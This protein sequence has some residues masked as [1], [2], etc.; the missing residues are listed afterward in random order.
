M[1]Q[2]GRFLLMVILAAYFS[3]PV[4][5]QDVCAI[6]GKPITGQFYLVTDQVSGEQ[7]KVCS[8]CIL[9]PKCFICGLPVKTGGT[10]LSDGRW[11]C[12]RDS[13]TAVMDVDTARQTANETRDDL[14][15]VFS[16][17]TSWPTNVHI[18]VIDRI[19]V[20]TM[21]Q[22]AGNN[23]ESPNLM[24]CIQQV[25][26]G[27]KKHYEMRLLTGLP[28]VELRATAAHEFSHAWVGENVSPERHANIA[29][30]AE[31]GFCEMVAY[32]LMDSEGQ[33]AEKQFILRNHYTRGQVQLFIAAEQQYGFDQILDWMKYG[34]T[35]ELEGGHLDAI[36]DVKM[37]SGVA[38]T[39]SS[40]LYATAAKTPVRAS[41][42]LELQGI[43]WG[44][45]PAAIINNQ[46]VFANDQFKVNI[47]GKEVQVRCLQI[48]TN[49]VRVKNLGSGEEQQ[50]QLWNN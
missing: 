39:A 6:C 4:L 15:Q 26:D 44:N 47:G 23:F 12:A 29:R 37:P 20:D 34:E 49:F 25:S 42:S 2:A 7:K 21:F 9:L 43:L 3:A 10:Q 13:Q 8:T 16:R 35:S 45:P 33:E 36:R 14:D 38:A 46:T 32:L 28:L 17:Y 1:Q 30:D 41:S 19:D 24:G 27:G 40:A 22:P 31:E 18:N 48:Q 11:L 50:L 5:A